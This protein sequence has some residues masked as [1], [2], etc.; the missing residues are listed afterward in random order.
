MFGMIGALIGWLSYHLGLRTD[1][2]S[3]TGSLHAKV[4][5]LSSTQVGD[6]ADVRTDNTLFGW[7]NTQIKSYQTGEKSLDTSTATSTTVT[8]SAVVIAKCIV[9]FTVRC[10]S[11]ATLEGTLFTGYL[12]NDTTLTLDRVTGTNFNTLRIRWYVIELY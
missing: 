10:G 12:S 2:A 11:A 7:A 3:S 5:Y 9:L 6:S 1:A 4:K 8:I